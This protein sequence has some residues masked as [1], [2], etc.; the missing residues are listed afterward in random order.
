MAASSSSSQL[1]RKH[2]DVYVDDRLEGGEA[3]SSA[4]MNAID[5]SMIALVIFSKDYASSRWCL[6][7]L[8][9]IME[10]QGERGQFANLEIRL[11]KSANLSG[12]HSSEFQN[13]SKLI[14]AI[15]EDVLKKL[16]DNSPI[17][18]KSQLIGFHQN[19][20]CVESLMEIQ[21]QEVRILGIWGMGGIGKTTLARAIFDK[22]LS[23]F[24]SHCFLE[25]VREK[26]TKVDGLKSLHQELISKLLEKKDH[27]DM[28]DA[29][30][31]LQGKK[32]AFNQNHP[33]IGYQELSKTT[34]AIAQGIPLAL[35]VLGSHFHSRDEAYWENK[36]LIKS[37][38][39]GDI[40]M[41]DLIREMAEQIVRNEESVSHPE[42]R[43]RLKN[44]D[45]IYDVLK[46][47]MD[48]G[49]LKTINL[50][51]SY[52]LI[53]LPDL[54]MAHKLESVNLQGCTNLRSVHPS[55]LSLPSI[56]KMN[57]SRCSKLESI[58][59]ETHL[60]SFSDL[61]AVYCCLKKLCLSSNDSAVE[62]LPACVNHLSSLKYIYLR[63]PALNRDHVFL[64]PV[65]RSS[66]DAGIG[67]YAKISCELFLEYWNEVEGDYG[68]DEEGDYGDDEEGDYGDD[69]EADYLDYEEE[70]MGMMRRQTIRIMR[71]QTMGI[72]RRET[73]GIV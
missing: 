34:V 46:S 11:K 8:V 20:T 68:D 42:R 36:A 40:V 57:I 73:I 22:F 66:Y 39:D 64:W 7:E 49:N 48:L 30:R 10:F 2:I 19:F 56:I 37:N 41:H 17:T 54:S 43:S 63:S 31:R 25:N 70:T 61:S 47:N 23:E 50:R 24:E 14:D 60:E 53:E 59:S 21:L 33:N 29:M 26:S 52:E 18:P 38:Q 62:T 6:E 27:I 45:E 5:G 4:L 15:V 58:E 51:G 13:E 67:N 44:A 9:K 71:R 16:E 12:Y 32:H 69:E 1:R 3:I 65:R 35:E 72:M 55:I 28:N